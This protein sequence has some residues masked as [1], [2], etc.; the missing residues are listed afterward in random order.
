MKSLLLILLILAPVLWSQPIKDTTYHIDIIITGSPLFS[1][2]SEARFPGASK[3]MIVGYGGYLRSMWH[4]GRMISI[5][6]MIGYLFITEDKIENNE[7]ALRGE[8][9][10][11]QLIA[12]PLQIAVSMQKNNIELGVGM[13]PYLMATT[14]QYGETAKGNRLELGLTFFGSYCFLLND[15]VKI[16]PEFKLMYLGYRG[17]ISIMP[18]VSLCFNILRY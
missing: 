4:P 6:L 3:N 1:F 10:S 11:A 15:Y 13:G 5:G 18:S 2:F 12:I 8:F 9:A 16:G 7:I 14:I 17:I